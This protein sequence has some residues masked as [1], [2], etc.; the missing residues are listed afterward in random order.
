MKVNKYILC[1]TISLCFYLVI[2]EVFKDLFEIRNSNFYFYVHKSS[3]LILVAIL[4]LLVFGLYKLRSNWKWLFM[5]PVFFFLLVVTV[6]EFLLPD[7]PNQIT[8]KEDTEI[9]FVDRSNKNKKIIRQAF[10]TGFTGDSYHSDTIEVNEINAYFRISA[11]VRSD[12]L[13]SNWI[14]CTK[15]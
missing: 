6:I 10:W 12:T 15:P 8:I 1:G 7:F 5:L 3:A 11:C 4:S 13:G 9:L 14:K 2:D